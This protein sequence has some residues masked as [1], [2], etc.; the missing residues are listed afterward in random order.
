MTD[1]VYVKWL[2][3][4]GLEEIELVGGKNASLGEMLRGLRDL[5][6]IPSGFVI[7]SHAYDYFMKYN[8][9]HEEIQQI[10]THTDTDSL[11]ELMMNGNIIRQKIYN[12]K[13]PPALEKDI[14]QYYQDFCNKY[15]MS[16]IDVAVRS[17]GTAEDLPD[18]SFAGQQDTYLN[19]RGSDQVLDKV[20]ACFASLYTDRA[21]CYR[22]TMGF[23][24]PVRISVCVQKMVRS[25]IGCSGVAF[26]I[27]PDSGF[28]D[29]VCINGS[30]GLGEMVVSGQVKP[31]E[32]LVFKP[33]LETH[34]SIITKTLGDKDHKMIYSIDPAKRTR[35]VATELHERDSYCLN[36]EQVL[37]LARW[38]VAIEKYYS[39][40]YGRW[41]PVDVEWAYD[42]QLHQLFIV[43]ARPETIH[44]R[45]TNQ[46]E[47]T[48]YKLAANIKEI[49]TV[50][51]TGVAV[52]QSIG[53]GKVRC[54]SSINSA[55]SE[56]FA[57]GDVLVTEYTD[58]T[59]EPLMKKASAIITDK[60][61]RTSHAA[62]VSRELGKTALVGCGN[63]TQILR[64]GQ[65]VSVCC[66]VGD[67]GYV[68][69]GEIPFT[70]IKT[71][72]SALPSLEGKHTRVMLNVGNPDNCFRYNPYPVSGV[73]LAREEFII[74]NHIGIHPNAVLKIDEMPTEIKKEIRQRARGYAS[75]AEWYE[76]RLADGIA[77]ISA[78]FY[79]RPVI[80]RFSDFKSNEYKDL[81][82][83]DIFEPNEENPMLGF[84]G[85]SRYYSESFKEA[86]KMECNAIKRV[87]DGMGLTNTIVML[88]FCR[89]VQECEK[90]LA[91]MKEFGL[92]RGVNGLQVY[93]MCEIP[94]NVILADDFCKY[95]DGFSIGSND[96][97][98]LCLGLD[99]DAGTL[100][101][102]GNETNP[103][104]KKMIQMAIES[105]KRNGVKIGICGQ[106]PSDIPE[107]AKFLM[108]LEI[109]SI[110][111]IPD[112]IKDFLIKNR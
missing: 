90:T 14:L 8:N 9:L 111:L 104:V 74:A 10:I 89:T 93:L 100:T 69:K 58:P 61:G 85:C 97:T 109:D 1:Y 63:A 87:R 78:T 40:K 43:Q 50:L 5:C 96:L 48:E 42:G 91:T 94:S 71:N 62:I 2:E 34:A 12:S 73:G 26:S 41:C 64:D 54:I 21:I 45:K 98:Q 88:P 47:F 20:R 84:R 18:A 30:V 55:E 105:C 38:V 103:A 86:F 6:Q 19:V 75:V 32:F 80:V 107:F 108:D 25:D 49:E 3:E 72:L 17:S 46:T 31:D 37:E 65:I 68:F 56:L 36:D 83:G 79:P 33:T 23:D 82:G 57:D 44:S 76:Q 7:T 99:R 29:V 53:V 4:T 77:L 92:E 81:L 67:T 28:R 51:C 59:Y 52:G 101:H 66:A 22:K 24:K 106:G 13:T 102:I 95:V 39:N 35:I 11:T 60:G 15:Q 16:N 112:S 70:T 27:H 110:S